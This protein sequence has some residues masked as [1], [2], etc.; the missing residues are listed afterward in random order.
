MLFTAGCALDTL[1]T[2]KA[3][4]QKPSA[5]RDRFGVCRTGRRLHALDIAFTALKER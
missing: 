3:L 4:I 1:T 5:I 2:E